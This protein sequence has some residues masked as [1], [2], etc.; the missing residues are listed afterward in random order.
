MPD[1]ELTT[2]IEQ[3]KRIVPHFQ[4][5]PQLLIQYRDL[6]RRVSRD[7]ELD[8]GGQKKLKAIEEIIREVIQEL[9]KLDDRLDD[10]EAYILAIA[11]NTQAARQATGVIDRM[12][13]RQDRKRLQQ[14]LEQEQRNLSGYELKIAQQGGEVAAELQLLH[15]RDIA[16]ESIERI[17]TELDKLYE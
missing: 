1:D 13:N 15:R 9:S 10:I 16:K 12:Q 11:T 14:L 6:I 2:L 3:I 5:L 7:D 8:R 17:T 4:D